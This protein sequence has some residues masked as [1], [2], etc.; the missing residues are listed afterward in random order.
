MFTMISGI[1]IFPQ[2]EDQWI[3][4]LSLT[5][6]FT[7]WSLIW[8]AVQKRLFGLFQPADWKGPVKKYIFNK[9]FLKFLRQFLLTF[10]LLYFMVT[11]ENIFFNYKLAQYLNTE[12]GERKEYS[13][14][15]QNNIFLGNMTLMLLSL[16]LFTKIDYRLCRIITTWFS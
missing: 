12:L 11:L 15:A 3:K 13:K 6:F 5:Y 8:V 7:P 10:F 2:I 14:M 4:F 9:L 16:K 1:C